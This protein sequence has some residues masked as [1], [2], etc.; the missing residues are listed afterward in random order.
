LA[1][2]RLS[3]NQY[4]FFWY[5]LS[6]FLAVGGVDETLRRLRTFRLNAYIDLAQLLP[7]SGVCRQR[8]SPLKAED[9]SISLSKIRR[10]SAID[11]GYG[12]VNAKKEEIPG[13]V[14]S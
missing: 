6:L 14:K 3:L 11:R 10:P 12:F 4:G 1:S 5:K 2:Q 13:N 7:A 9:L 8:S